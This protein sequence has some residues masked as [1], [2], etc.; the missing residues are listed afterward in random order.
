MLVGKYGRP[1][2]CN[3]NSFIDIQDQ[4]NMMMHG[5]TQIKFINVDFSFIHL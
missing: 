3:N 1:T 2:R 5:Q 4:L